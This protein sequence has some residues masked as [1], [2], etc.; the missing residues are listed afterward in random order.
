MEGKKQ[1]EDIYISLKSPSG[2]FLGICIE[3]PKPQ[4]I[5][6]AFFSFWFFLGVVEQ[7]LYVTVRPFPY[8]NLV[9]LQRNA[10][11]HNFL[12]G[13]STDPLGMS[14]LSLRDLRRIFDNLDKNGD[15]LL[16]LE[17]LNWL[18][19]MVGHQLSLEDLESSIGK[20]A[21]DFN[22]FLIFHNSISGKSSGNDGTGDEAGSSEN[23]VAE[24]DQDTDLL[25]A[26]RVFDLDGDGFISSEELQSLLSRLELWDERSG[27]DCGRMINAYDSNRD[28]RL[29]FEEFK[30]MML[31]TIS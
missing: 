4:E 28:G 31:L 30:N 9:L 16:S 5:P 24:A 10:Q 13:S 6:H 25:E 7:C 19:N 22:E 26:F 29:D 21:L 8:K 18:L 11:W 1:E 27:K 3:R 12:L 14:S 20:P 23:A 2:N 15:G 17:E